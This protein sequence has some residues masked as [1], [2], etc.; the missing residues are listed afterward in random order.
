[1]AIS[2]QN[3]I[4]Y[5][6][7]DI[8]NNTT[9]CSYKASIITTAGSFNTKV[10]NGTGVFDG[11]N[12]SFDTIIPQ[13]STYSI[14]MI[15]R[16]V[17]HNNDGTKTV[18][19][20]FSLATGTDAGTIK[21][22]ASKK[23][24]N[25]PRYAD[26]DSVVCDTD[27]LDGNITIKFTPKTKGLYYNL[28]VYFSKNGDRALLRY[29]ELG[30][31]D[32][33]EQQTVTFK[34]RDVGELDAIYNAHTNTVN[35]Q[36][37][38]KIETYADAN[39][40]KYYGSSEELSLNLEIPTSIKP[41]VE[42]EL[43]PVNCFKNNSGDFIYLQGYSKVKVNINKVTSMFGSNIKQYSMLIDNQ[44]YEGASQIHTSNLLTNAGNIVIKVRAKD[45]R[46]RV[47]EKIYK[48]TV[49]SY[50]R[51]KLTIDAYRA[52]DNKIKDDLSGANIL[53][54]PTFSFS[55]SIPGNS[56]VSKSVKI[57]DIQVTTEFITKQSLLFK[58]YNINQNH[59]VSVSI[60]DAVG[61]TTTVTK[62]VKKGCIPF[63]INS[64]KT[65]V[66][67]G[68][69]AEGDGECQ[70][71][72]IL[73]LF[74][75]LQFKGISIWDMIF[76]KGYQ[77]C[78]SDPNFNPNDKYPG[79][80]WKRLKGVVLG[81]INESDTDT[82]VKTSFNQKAG[83]IIGSKYL[84]QHNHPFKNGSN[85]W[86]WGI[87]AGGTVYSPTEAIGGGV[88]SGHNYITTKQGVWNSSDNAGGGDSEN[89][90]PTLLTY[91]WE[92]TA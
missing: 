36:L 34:L 72:Y 9:N 74:D 88:P 59:K 80:T 26:L 13:N 16:T 2:V 46:N 73:N 14:F 84:Q 90:Q 58:G 56:I 32:S 23:L 69:L 60:T 68:K 49:Y 81:A 50:K 38:F 25:I 20:S 33:A 77:M 24:P 18:T 4:T 39:N 55:S 57:N 10:V 17:S 21:G 19:G 71:G 54:K 63:N 78:V 15:N 64:E 75:G 1:M 5:Y 85:T 86:L 67:I 37:L 42:A 45:N 8:K 66:G 43:T 41:I 51:P 52:D 61:N 35:V 65:G 48:I 47:G 6:G 92:R 12:F 28:G 89:I 53:V 87:E 29:D 22:S 91:I 44:Y 3:N 7:Q 83:T 62:I 76:P 30:L 11:V 79:T 40:N 31:R 70:I 27:Y 82:N